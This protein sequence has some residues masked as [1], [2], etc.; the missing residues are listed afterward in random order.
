MNKEDERIG[1]E[2][3]ISDQ[4]SIVYKALIF[5]DKIPGYDKSFL[6]KFLEGLEKGKHGL[7]EDRKRVDRICDAIEYFIGDFGPD[8]H[9]YFASDV[10]LGFFKIPQK[11]EE[12][13]ILF[14][15]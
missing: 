11:L 3:G 10:K 13:G 6:L 1:D 15:D 5:L 8:D 9:T 12:K 14:I 4:I 2:V 7:A